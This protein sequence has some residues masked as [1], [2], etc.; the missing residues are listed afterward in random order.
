MESPQKQILVLSAKIDA[1]NKMLEQVSS[2]NSEILLRVKQGSEAEAHDT[3]LN[4]RR[5]SYAYSPAKNQDT[6]MTHKDVLVDSTGME[7]QGG[8]RSLSP[9]I[10]IQ[11]LTAQLTAAYNRIA[12]LEEQLLAHRM[13]H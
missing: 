5:S 9:E 4:F 10:Q 7:T 8:E 6:G 3:H 13:V 2:Q 11:R 1:L 12:A